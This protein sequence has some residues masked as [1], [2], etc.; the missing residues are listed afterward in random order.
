MNFIEAKSHGFSEAAV[1][2]LIHHV[3]HSLFDLY[4]L[5]LSHNDVKPENIVIGS[6]LKAKL[7]DFGFTDSKNEHSSVF[8]IGT[9]LYNSPELTRGQP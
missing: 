8:N 5:G 2:V 1:R 3:L 4:K 6:D 7:I 9:D